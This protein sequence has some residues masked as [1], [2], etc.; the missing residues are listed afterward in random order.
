[1]EKEITFKGFNPIVVTFH[2][3]EPIRQKEFSEIPIKKLMI[4]GFP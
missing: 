4:D 3:N 1:M 2:L